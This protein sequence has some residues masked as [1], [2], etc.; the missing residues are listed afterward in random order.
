MKKIV[1]IVLSFTLLF[2]LFGCS[3]SKYTKFSKSFLNLFD[4]ASSITAYDTSQA[5]FNKKYNKLYSVIKGY[6]ELYDIYNDY[7]N[8]VNLKYINDNAL[9]VNISR[10]RSKLSNFGYENILNHFKK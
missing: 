2:T 4:T 7:D 3:N 10:L 5:E 1:S 8:I 9:T 6:S